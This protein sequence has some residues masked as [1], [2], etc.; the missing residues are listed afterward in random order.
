MWKLEFL[1]PRQPLFQAYAQGMVTETQQANPIR[2]SGPNWLK[3]WKEHHLHIT[4]P[5]IIFPALTYLTHSWSSCCPR[6]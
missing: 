6:W 5:N 2:F 4:P 1:H 3:P